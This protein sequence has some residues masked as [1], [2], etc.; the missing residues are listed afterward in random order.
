M[1]RVR[2]DLPVDE[3]KHLYQEKKL[4]LS[5]IAKMLNCSDRLVGINLKRYGIKRRSI[6]EAT[7]KGTPIIRKDGYVHV[8]QPHNPRANNRGYVLEH[9]LIAEKALG[10]FLPLQART[11]HYNGKEN[12]HAI[13]ICQ[14]TKYHF[15]LHRRTNNLKRQRTPCQNCSCSPIFY[16]KRELCK[17]CYHQMWHQGLLFRNNSYNHSSYK[18]SLH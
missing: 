15:L 7:F 5:Q 16:L 13:V 17:K 14:D 3:I 2:K 18:N 4:S 10:K 9:I 11:H 12:K 6:S 1:W 8:Y